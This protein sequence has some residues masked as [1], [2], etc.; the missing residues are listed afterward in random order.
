MSALW[1]A[2]N[3]SLCTDYVGHGTG[4]SASNVAGTCI[5][6]ACVYLFPG[7][8]FALIDSD[9]IPVT[10]YEIQELWCSCG[11]LDHVSAS[12]ALDHT[13]T[14]PIA[15]AHKRARSVDTVDTGKPL[16]SQA[17]L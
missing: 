11:D 17:H 8:N 4:K 14:S 2:H 10:L 6:D 15:P 1:R 12:V 13:S 7:T 9:C 16:S 3:S 5:L